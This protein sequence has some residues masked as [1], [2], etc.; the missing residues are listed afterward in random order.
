M[1]D[2]HKK[3]DTPPSYSDLTDGELLTLTLEQQSFAER[4]H[5]ALV[6]ELRRRG[7][8]ETD[9]A[10]FRKD[11][12]RVRARQSR[13]RKTQRMRL[14]ETFSVL[15]VWPGMLFIPFGLA[16][17]LVFVLD[18]VLRDVLGLSQHQ[19]NLCEEIAA[20]GV[21]VLCS[22]TVAAL[23]V[24]ERGGSPF[25]RWLR[26]TQEPRSEEE[27]RRAH[28]RICPAQN[29]GNA[30][31]L[32]LFSLYLLFLNV[33]DVVGWRFFWRQPSPGGWP[34]V[35]TVS[36]IFVVVF[37][38]YLLVKAPCFR[39]KLWLTFVTVNLLLDL[40]RH[41]LHNLTARELSLSSNA[42]LILWAAATIVALSFVKSA[43]Q[44]PETR[45][46]YRQL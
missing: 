8:G 30:L 4:T 9:I 10:A 1:S 38:L 39:E 40:P 22:V 43:W 26:G 35:N 45:K 7:L 42:S 21:V 13:W 3:G 36:S 2:E 20:I 5:E 32:F 18:L 46:P 34:Y 12:G 27:K 23:I 19:T 25:R 37:C 41:L 24:S 29:L 33:G 16:V 28:L 14:R 44:G 15:L 6:T 17:A 31:L 11:E